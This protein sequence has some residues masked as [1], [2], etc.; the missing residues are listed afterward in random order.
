M[1]DG[2]ADD[3]ADLPTAGRD[4]GGRLPAPGSLRLIQALVNTS[5]VEFDRELIGSPATAARWL[6]TAGLLDPAVQLTEPEVRALIELREAIREVL[7]AHN[8]GQ[9]D[10]AAATRLTMAL[11][12]SR[13]TVT[14]DPAGEVH[15]AGADRDPFTRA[16]APSP[17]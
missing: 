13:L 17:P 5:A 10:P 2:N 8:A 15:L 11:A 16:S 14:V 6:V 4:P 12:C 1:S 7:A 3:L 9:P